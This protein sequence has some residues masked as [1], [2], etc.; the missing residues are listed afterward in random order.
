MAADTSTTRPGTSTG[1]L[2]LAPLMEPVLVV[3][4]GHVG[5]HSAQVS[6]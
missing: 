4:P 3:V 2:R 6:R 1:A 5:E